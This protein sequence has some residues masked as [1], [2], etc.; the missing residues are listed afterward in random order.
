MHLVRFVVLDSTRVYDPT[1]ERREK[2]EKEEIEEADIVDSSSNID[3]QAT[4]TLTWIVRLRFFS[5]SYQ[6]SSSSLFYFT[7]STHLDKG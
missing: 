7:R 5:L 6:N 2:E 1:G 4:S 3:S